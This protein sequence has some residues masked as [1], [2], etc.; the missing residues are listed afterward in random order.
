MVTTWKPFQSQRPTEHQ[1]SEWLRL[2]PAAWAMITGAISGRITLDFDGEPGRQTLQK[3]RLEPHRSTPSD[4]YHAD[5]VHPGWHVPTLNAKTKRELGERWPGLD[6]R[7]DGGYVVFTGRTERGE[8]HWLRDPEPYPLDI[9]PTDLR[10]FLGLLQPPAAPAPIQPQTNR[11]VH[12]TYPNGRVDVERLIRM[13]LDRMGSEGRN[14]AGFWLAA[15]LRDNGYSFMEAE[16]AMRIYRDRCPVTN[17][18]G[19][20]EPYNE[21]EVQATLREVYARGAREPWGHSGHILHPT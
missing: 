20:R 13:A 7:A 21:Q 15:Q 11:K 4:G 5:F 14:N 16:L 6:I 19:E 3:L 9:L 10:E 1:L 8:Y 12:T 18:K 17:I 2:N